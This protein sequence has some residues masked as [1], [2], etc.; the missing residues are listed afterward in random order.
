[1]TECIDLPEEVKIIFD[2]YKEYGATAYVVGGCIR[3][4]LIGREVHDWD[5]CTPVI[6]AETIEIFR[7]KGYQVIETGLQ[8]GT[9][10]VM[11]N[12]K[13][14]EITVFRR[15][16][17]YSDGRHPD[18]VEFTNNIEEDLSRRDFTMNAVA[19]NPE[20]GFIDPFGG[21]SD[22]TRKCIKCV[23]TPDE[24]FREDPLR[25]MR[26]I[27]FSAQLGFMIDYETLLSAERARLKLSFVSAERKRDELCKTIMSYSQFLYQSLMKNQRIIY[28]IIPELYY[29]RVYQRNPYHIYNVYE[30]SIYAMCN[31]FENQVIRLT[32][33]FHDIGKPKSKTT[34]KNGID[35]FYGHAE[36]GAKMTDEI[37]RRLRFDNDTREAVVELVRNHDAEISLKKSGIKRWLNKLGEEQFRRLLEVKAAD[38][39]AHNPIYMKER[40][41]KIE[42]IKE[43]LEEVL[44]EKSCF[45]LKNLMIDGYDLI[46][47]GYKPGKELGNAL[48]ELLSLVI[49]EEIQNKQSVLLA[50]AE[51][52]LNERNIQ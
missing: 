26:C 39:K 4:N 49:D 31:S 5:I 30:H 23:G 33:L 2:A 21:M 24:R 35:H 36:V 11:I 25:I 14:F 37:M 6:P 50:E 51:R 32:L 18:N 15:D 47:I 48:N 3:D 17:K 27:R 9:V 52:I 7:E 46:A 20:E 43:L 34:D 13:A 12:D 22:I 44:E 29:C 28:A 42:K 19:Y 40:L 8:H 10:T 45:T 38:T 41:L 1:M 16:G